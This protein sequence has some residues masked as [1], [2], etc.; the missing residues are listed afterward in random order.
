MRFAFP[1]EDTGGRNAVASQPRTAVDGG[2]VIGR[3]YHGSPTVVWRALHRYHG[4]PQ[5]RPPHSPPDTPY[6]RPDPVGRP[7]TATVVATRNAIV[8]CTESCHRFE[9]RTV[10]GKLSSRISGSPC[11][12]RQERFVVF[13]VRFSVCVG[14]IF[15]F[16]LSGTIIAPAPRATRRRPEF[17]FWFFFFARARVENVVNGLTVWTKRRRSNR[18]QNSYEVMSVRSQITF[19]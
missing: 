17:A 15:V 1:A 9:I 13:S 10:R 4:P 6:P 18:C 3:R 11:R 5:R 14:D 8:P 19:T 2:V 12:P 16:P 7:T